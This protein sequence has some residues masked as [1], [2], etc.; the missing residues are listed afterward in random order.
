MDPSINLDHQGT[1]VFKGNI[2]NQFVV[3]EQITDE[4]AAQ[5]KQEAEDKLNKGD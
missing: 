1:Y 3:Q 2:G 5:M 4:V